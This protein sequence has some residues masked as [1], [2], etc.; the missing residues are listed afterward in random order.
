MA[1]VEDLG[2]FLSDMNQLPAL[3]SC[4]LAS[5]E[6]RD[7]LI[8]LSGDP[9][10]MVRSSVILRH[11]TS[12]L[13]AAT[14]KGL[15]LLAYQLAPL[16]PPRSFDNTCDVRDLVLL[17]QLAL[18]ATGCADAFVT[19]MGVQHNHVLAASN[20]GFQHTVLPREHA[21]CQ[22]T[23]LTTRPFLV[24]HPEA[25][26]RFHELEA[27]KT[28]SIRYYVGFPVTVRILDENGESETE[29]AVGTLCCTDRTARAE[30]TR[31]QYA[32]MKRL[33]DTASR[34]IQLKGQQLL[35]QVG[36]ETPLDLGLCLEK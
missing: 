6:R 24:T 8:E 3:E 17:C 11:D 18:L 30:L 1:Y 19:V 15:L 22:H 14:D 35:R 9:V 10:T 4:V 29:I 23:I 36:K 28:L 32:T 33:S 25:D 5:A 12:R 13:K 16:Q 27:V 2:K 31:S 20:P 34:L 26:V 21:I 7:Y